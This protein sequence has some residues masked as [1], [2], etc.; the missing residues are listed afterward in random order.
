MR[1]RKISSRINLYAIAHPEAEVANAAKERYA[2]AQFPV[3]D[4]IEN[5]V[6]QKCVR[7]HTNGHQK[8]C[9]IAQA[10]ICDRI[11]RQCYKNPEFLG[12]RC[13]FREGFW[14][15]F[16]GADTENSKGFGTDFELIKGRRIP[17]TRTLHYS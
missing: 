17:T 8:A 3:C 10:L 2:L 12:F 15:G 6:A 16:Q 9:A 11:Y 1:S 4:R 14:H 13:G 7:S 5:P